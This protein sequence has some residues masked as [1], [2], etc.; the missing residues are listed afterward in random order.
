M[1]AKR[2]SP[3]MPG[4]VVG[5]VTVAPWTYGAGW[6]SAE[7][8]DSVPSPTATAQPALSSSFALPPLA[9]PGTRSVAR[10]D[11]LE[12]RPG[13][14]IAARTQQLTS[15]VGVRGS[16]G[17]RRARNRGRSAFRGVV[18]ATVVL[19]GAGAIWVGAT[20]WMA[21][22]ELNAVRSGAPV[23]RAQLMAADIPAATASADLI[24]RQASRSHKLT[25]GPAWALIS[26]VPILGDPFRT[27]R[28][29][30]G[31][32][33]E[34]GRTAL[35]QLVEA[36]ATI[37]PKQLR[38][39]DGTIDVAALR[40]ITPALDSA[41]S[42]IDRVIGATEGLPDETY[43]GSVDRARTELLEELRPLARMTESSIQASRLL[44]VM[45]GVDKPQ[46]YF[47]GFQ[48]NA[49]AR[50]TGGLPGA[51]AIVRADR[52]HL[53]FVGFHND[54]ELFG[55]TAK[56]RFDE[57]YETL[58]Q[59][60]A[61]KSLF[62]NSN[63]SPHFPYAAQIWAD[64]WRQRSGQSVDGV[65]AVDPEVL[66]YLLAVTGPAHLADGTEVS[67]ANVVSLT[68]STAYSRFGDDNAARKRFLI[69][70]AA[71]AADRLTSA[72]G[73]PAALARALARA[74]NERRLLVWSADPGVQ[75]QL[76]DTELSGAVPDS[77]DAYVG[78]TVINEGGNKLDYYLDRALTW[79]RRG[80]GVD[81][82]V[83]V[84]V[85]LTNSA[86]PGL[87]PVYVAPRSDNPDYA[88]QPGDNRV[89]L[90]YTATQGAVLKSATINGKPTG[91]S[92]GVERGHPVFIVDVELPRGKPRTVVLT[93]EEPSAPGEPIVLRQPLVRPLTVNVRDAAC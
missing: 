52:G 1:P 65:I 37:D 17:R 77:G 78:L 85:S 10:C 91:I 21:R 63:L 14:N 54:N 20:A 58:Y 68:Q 46:T 71:G 80:C 3:W 90:Y 81:R 44:P 79:E 11:F 56:V 53:D 24:A 19:I 92:A 43:L 6:A 12:A 45:L 23:L 70:V 84:T 39:D 29:I 41:A 16:R 83:I 61:T 15:G 48:N 28:G 76:E 2:M 5:R 49:E 88:T 51:F 22:S 32:A 86:P 35:P 27:A 36:G 13:S 18:L 9:Q 69:D 30:T 74:A 47:L 42:A 60:A 50:G 25:S 31:V 7:P 73:D 55:I 33:D 8:A 75:A 62:V 59:N 89:S 66:S 64:M 72:A 4:F 67:A 40:R 87:S 34:L 93:L 26:K 57:D 38:A 82:D